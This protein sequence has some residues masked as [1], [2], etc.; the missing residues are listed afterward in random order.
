M[1]ELAC[2]VHSRPHQESRD[3]TSIRPP[4][5]HFYEEFRIPDSICAPCGVLLGIGLELCVRRPHLAAMRAD[6]AKQCCNSSTHRGSLGSKLWM[7]QHVGQI[8]WIAGDSS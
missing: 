4:A 7:R 2:M 8:R 5:S 3:P 6:Q 1:S